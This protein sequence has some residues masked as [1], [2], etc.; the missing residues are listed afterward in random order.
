M[1]SWD[2]LCLSQ[3]KEQS[4]E[5]RGMSRV[6]LGNAPGEGP[7]PWPAKTGGPQPQTAEKPSDRYLGVEL[8]SPEC[9]ASIAGVLLFPVIMEGFLREA[10]QEL[11]ASSQASKA[12]AGEQGEAPAKGRPGVCSGG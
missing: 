9:T 4:R 12:D 1:E 8:P 10:V 2:F 3:G 7:R 6:A 11:M 5:T